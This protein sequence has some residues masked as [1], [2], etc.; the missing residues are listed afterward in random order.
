MVFFNLTSIVTERGNVESAEYEKSSV[1]RSVAVGNKYK[2]ITMVFNK[3]HN[4]TTLHF[5][6]KGHYANVTEKFEVRWRL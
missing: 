5:H 1:I 3:G 2:V 6:L 4:L